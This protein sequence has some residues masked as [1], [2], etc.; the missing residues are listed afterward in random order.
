M[1]F[2]PGIDKPELKHRDDCMGIG[3]TSNYLWTKEAMLFWMK[4]IPNDKLVMALP[5]YANDYAVTG[6]IK[7]RQVYQSV[8]DSINGILPSPTWLCY[9]KVNMY[10]YDGTDGNRHLFYASDAR[11]TEALL[12]LADELGISQI[13]F[14]HF[15]S[16]DPQMW[17][18]TAKW[19]KK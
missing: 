18:T 1:Y 13:G 4:H 12:E 19:Q 17:D 2:A 14:W 3:P 16:V 9:E 10:L 7:G 8:P 5:A 15:N 6:D 11:S